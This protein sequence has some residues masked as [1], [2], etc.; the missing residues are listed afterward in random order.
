MLLNL[1]ILIHKIKLF[2]LIQY[3]AEYDKILKESHIQ[4]VFEPEMLIRLLKKVGLDVIY[5]P[6]FIEKEKDLY[7]GV[8]R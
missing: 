8:K 6:D 4:R 3:D 5:I 1:L 2:Y 7:I